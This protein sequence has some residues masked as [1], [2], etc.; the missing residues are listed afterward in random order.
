MFPGT[1]CSISYK[2]FSECI[3]HL[4][5]YSFEVL[6]FEELKINSMVEKLIDIFSEYLYL[7]CE[8]DSN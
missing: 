4:T 2:S 6:Y 5:F 8:N 3:Y 7:E 1:V